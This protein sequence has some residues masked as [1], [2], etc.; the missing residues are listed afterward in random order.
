[1]SEQ[2]KPIRETYRFNTEL[3]SLA[4]DDL[5]QEDAVRRWK[6]GEGSSIAYLTG[7]ISSSRYG[8]LKALGRETENPYKELYGAGVGSKDGSAYPP[9]DELAAGWRQTAEKLHAALDAVSDEDALRPSDGSFPTADQ[10]LRGQLA[11]IAWHESYHVGQ[12]GILRTEMGY[13]S[14]RQ[15]LYAVRQAAGG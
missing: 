8:I 11:F 2:I 1:M 7:H 14:L 9:L 10:T 6:D 3:V 4:L 13:T 12:I 5:S 15:R